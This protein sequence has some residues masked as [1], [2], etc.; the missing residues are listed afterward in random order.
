MYGAP[1]DDYQYAKDQYETLLEFHESGRLE[2]VYM[3]AAG[4]AL[5]VPADAGAPGGFLSPRRRICQWQTRALGTPRP[6]ARAQR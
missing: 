1:E 3:V 4:L 6:G 5:A 2:W